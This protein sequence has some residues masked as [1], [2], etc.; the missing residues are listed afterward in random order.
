MQINNYHKKKILLSE[1]Y[2]IHYIFRNLTILI[3]IICDEGK[4]KS[5]RVNRENHVSRK[6]YDIVS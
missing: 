6:I 4:F 3:N 5:A 2:G 1:I